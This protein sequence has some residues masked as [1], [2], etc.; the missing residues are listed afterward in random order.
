VGLLLADRCK[1]VPS[2][3]AAGELLVELA[4]GDPDADALA[5]PEGE[6]LD[7]AVAE[8]VGEPLD[9]AEADPV[10]DVDIVTVGSMDVDIVGDPVAD[11]LG[12]PDDEL[13]GETVAVSVGDTEVD[14]L[15]ETDGEFVADCDA[16]AVGEAEVE[17]V[18][19]PLAV[20]LGDVLTVAQ[21]P[22]SCMSLPL[23]DVSVAS[24]ALLSGVPASATSV[25]S[26]GVHTT[27]PL[28]D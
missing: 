4:D 15:G 1:L 10:G 8:T 12:E 11:A 26:V 14:P 2:T 24:P 16:D 22:E 20:G 27:A 6:L 23:G 5:E 9:D 18:A 19:V 28:P 7:V 21:R 13:V 17:S 3:L 25:S